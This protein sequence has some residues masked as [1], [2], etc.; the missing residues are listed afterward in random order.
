MRRRIL[1]AIVGVTAVATLVLTV[2]LALIIARRESADS[3]LELQRAAQRTTAGLSTAPGR[4]GEDIELPAV[5]EN[6]EVGV[7]SPDGR[8]LAGTGPETADPVTARA[9]HIEVNGVV[10]ADRVLADPVLVNEQLVAVVRVA[11]P[12][13]DTTDR[14]RRDLLMLIL[15]DLLAVA[16]AAAA[17]SFV[18]ARLARPVRRLRDDAVRL[19]D[20]DFAVDPLRSGIGEIDETS[21]ALSETAQRLEEMLGRERAFSADASHQLRT[22]LAA[23]RLSIETELLDPRP[24]AERVLDE[25]LTQVDRLE[26][27]ISTLLAIARDRPPP[28]DLLDVE[29]LTASLHRR[30][31]PRLDAT[32]RRLTC[33]GSD[34][35]DVHVSVAVLDQILD[36]LLANALE[37]GDGR[38]EVRFRPSAGGGLVVEVCDEGRIDRDPSSLFVRRDPAAAGHGVGLSLARSLAEAEGGRLVLAAA[39]PT[40]FRLVL[41]DAVGP[42][43]DSD[44]S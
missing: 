13:S 21:E 1:V 42:A 23:L 32:R 7:Y 18:A 5:E 3:V 12:A 35:V 15:F 20:G 10:G 44:S 6:L 37:H 30:C 14:V 38:V 9:R 24:D 29:R 39:T 22:P 40:T 8:K 25:A 43:R 11:E 4:D 28:R 31:G 17:G 2:P 34:R 26:E 41:P 33:A 27:T 19:G 36:I 16:V